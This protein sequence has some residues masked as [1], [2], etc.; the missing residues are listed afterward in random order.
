MIFDPSGLGFWLSIKAVK[1]HFRWFVVVLVGLFAGTMLTGCSVKSSPPEREFIPE[2]SPTQ[3]VEPRGSVYV[4]GQAQA[5]DPKQ[6]IL[7]LNGESLLLPSG[8]ARVVG[9]V[10]G[11]CPVACLEIG[12]RGLALGVGDRLDDYQVISIND[13]SIV[14]SRGK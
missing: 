8:Y 10:S 6:I 3:E 1:C 12:G 14:L 4:Y 5:N 7:K 11:G 9:V 13:R 2:V